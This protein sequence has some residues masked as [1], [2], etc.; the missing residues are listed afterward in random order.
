MA[1]DVIISIGREKYPVDIRA[2]S[3]AIKADEPEDVGGR[4]SGPNPYELLAAAIG[5]CKAITLRMYADRKGWA[6]EEVVLTVR[7]EKR[8]AEDC[9][10]CDERE[11]RLDHFDV[12][13]EP[14]G[15]LDEE[16]RRRLGEIADMCPVHRTLDKGV[17]VSTTV[18]TEER[19]G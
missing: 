16:Q 14:V 2:R 17:R 9:E 3:H 12:E 10:G 19:S 4:D 5:A 8:H 7:H 6:L 11:A 15:D 13:L 1:H 18:V